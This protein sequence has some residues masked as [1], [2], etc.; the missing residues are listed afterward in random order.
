[1][2]SPWSNREA[3]DSV[4]QL[5]GPRPPSLDNNASPRTHEA[6]TV[7]ITPEQRLK[8]LHPRR[9]FRLVIRLTDLEPL[10]PPSILV[11]G[12]TSKDTTVLVQ[13]AEEP[14]SELSR[15]GRPAPTTPTMMVYP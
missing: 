8:L 13:T 4:P 7:L 6:C 3:L 12:G 2:S 14:P 15:V 1:M 5:M 10:S 11:R 9:L